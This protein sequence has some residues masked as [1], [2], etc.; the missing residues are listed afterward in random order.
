MYDLFMS[1]DFVSCL[2]HVYRTL[3]VSRIQ[4][5]LVS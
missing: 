4:Y 3:V 5:D 2:M 1:F